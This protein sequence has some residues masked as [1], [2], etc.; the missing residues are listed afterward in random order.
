MTVGCQLREEL[1]RCDDF[2]SEA[3]V[4]EKIALDSAGGAVGLKGCVLD[5]AIVGLVADKFH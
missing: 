5:G 1:A 4:A 2:I 3:E